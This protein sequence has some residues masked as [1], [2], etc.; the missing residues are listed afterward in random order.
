MRLTLAS[1][2]LLSCATAAHAQSPADRC[3]AF[4]GESLGDDVKI[5][6]VAHI[7]AVGPGISP[8]PGQPPLTVGLP[9]HCRIEGTINQRIGAGGRSY[10]IGFAIAL[11]DDWNGRFLLQ[12]GGGLNGSVNPPIG[13]TAAGGRP[14]LTR[15]F[16]VI[17]HDSGHKGA[18]FDS[19]FKIDQRADLDFSEA[20]VK[21]V[22][23]L[24]KD[25]TRRFYGRPLGQSYM[26]GC[27]PGG[28]ARVLA[29]QRPAQLC[30]RR[31][32]RAPATH[33][34]NRHHGDPYTR[35]PLDTHPP[36][37]KDGKALVEQIFAPGDRA[38]ILNGLLKQCDGLDGLKD[39]MIENVA[40][41]RFQ[42]AKLQCKSGK[43]ADCLSA[44]QVEAMEAAFAGPKD[45]AGYPLYAPVPFDTGIVDDKS[46]LPG[47]LPTGKP[48]VF[49][50]V[51]RD[52]E[53]DLDARINE[54]R[55]DPG[56]R[57][58]DTNYWTNLNTFLDR[59]G[60]ILFFHGVSD[61]WFSAF[62]TWD[63]WQRARK[64]NG[65]A[66]DRASRFY[67]V[68]GMGHCG[69][70][71]AFDQFDLLGAVVDWVEQGK[72]P[73]AVTAS[74]RDPA[75]GTRPLCPFPR[76]AHHDG[77]DPKRAA[78]FSCRMPAQ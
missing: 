5:T 58:T 7:R 33:P 27:A 54:I 22:A 6:S 43:Q 51:S 60:K 62:D 1:L 18:V 74:R 71:N 44:A 39:G 42:P 56:Q 13:P 38:L 40:Q 35:L 23:L 50:P 10:G 48:G 72:A 53:I 12:G 20:S 32:A 4:A 29:P 36:P 24:G 11:P 15:G 59:G 78:S 17:S 57:L 19:S 8:G 28:G 46:P 26:A 3:G 14:A 64:A 25:I 61:P 66:W 68:P 34:G 67:M 37:D 70:G 55:A 30:H 2:A 77:G 41:C 52:L 45:K 65:E 63:Y 31:R 73:E 16:A 75:A 47:Y 69:G 21:T 9:A 76:Y 49:G